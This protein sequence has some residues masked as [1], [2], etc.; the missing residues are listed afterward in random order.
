MFCPLLCVPLTIALVLLQQVRIARKKVGGESRNT[1]SLFLECFLDITWVV[2]CNGYDTTYLSHRMLPS[3]NAK[4]GRYGRY[5]SIWTILGHFWATLGNFGIFLGHFG[6]ILG[7][8]LVLIFFGQKCISAI[9][10]TFASL[11]P[12]PSAYGRLTP[13]YIREILKIVTVY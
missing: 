10:I 2:L 4:S 5:I 8:F 9:F 1:E 13:P 12:R 6:S 3:R 7:Y 11:L